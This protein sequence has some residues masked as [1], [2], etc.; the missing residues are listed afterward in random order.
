[1]QKWVR[2]K[3]TIPMQEETDCIRNV[4]E[5]TDCCRNRCDYWRNYI[6]S[7][8]YTQSDMEVTGWSHYESN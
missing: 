6:H 3:I 5:G 1:M 2:K 8:E 4:M 7:K